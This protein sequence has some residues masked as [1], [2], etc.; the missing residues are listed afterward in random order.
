M[1][2]FKDR[3]SPRVPCQAVVIWID[4]YAYHVARFCGLQSAFGSSGEIVGLELIGG[5]GVHGGLK[6]R[7]E[8]PKD[9]P[10]ETLMPDK[11]WR[12][13]SKVKLSRM[14]WQK[15]SQLDPE[16]V[17]VPGYYTLPGLTAAMWTR[18]H[19]RVSVLMTESTEH[20]HMRSA[21]KEKAK[22]LL[23]RKLFD[24]AVTGGAAH[25]RYLRA[26]KFPED[27][28]GSFYD[29][30]GNDKLR[31]AV[32]CIRAA[33]DEAAHNLPKKYFLY[34]GR[35]AEEKNLDGLLGAWSEYRR[36]GGTRSLVIV[37][38]GPEATK[39]RVQAEASGFGSDIHFEG[40]KSSRELWPYFAFA[41]ALVLPSTREP[42]GLVVNEAMAAAL[43]VLVS[44]RCGS[45]QS[46][47]EHGVNGYIFEPE[48]TELLTAQLLAIDALSREEYSR[49]CDTSSRKIA[50]F[51][52]AHFGAQIKVIAS[53]SKKSDAASRVRTSQ[54]K[55]PSEARV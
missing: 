34:V 17:L 55:R 47:V 2:D 5:I 54:G 46:L 51:S 14:L 9:L 38:D 13:A 24:W 23:I 4:W 21:W 44:S 22:S 53:Q 8:L 1:S 30:I 35:L 19:N 48:Q 7:E 45:A 50:K 42:W 49:M 18:R 12:E 10:V 31:D 36:R 6:F 39:L 11:S 15:L 16:V 40:H 41:Y 29:V 37:G 25:V 33:S 3:N 43:P 27:R 28:I 20:D 26:L 52:P 32:S